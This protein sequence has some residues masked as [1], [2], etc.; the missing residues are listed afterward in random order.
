MK[1][2]AP[3]GD[4]AA[5][6]MPNQ[7]KRLTGQ[8]GCGLLAHR[9]RYFSAIARDFPLFTEFFLHHPTLDTLRIAA[10]EGAGKERMN[11]L[12]GGR[13]SINMF[14]V[15][16]PSD[17]RPFSVRPGAMQSLLENRKGKGF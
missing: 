11:D 1:A 3:A 13:G 7:G 14:L 8:N 16:S 5:N 6:P 2:E 15:D 10:P 4:E 9:K 17:L 12:T